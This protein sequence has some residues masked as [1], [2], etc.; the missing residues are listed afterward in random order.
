MREPSGLSAGDELVGRFK[1]LNIPKSSVNEF[2]SRETLINGPS[3]QV[4]GEMTSNFPDNEANRRS[5]GELDA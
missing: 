3:A 5:L 1:P 4:A 2:S